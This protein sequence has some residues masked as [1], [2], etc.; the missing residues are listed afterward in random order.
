M[1]AINITIFLIL[2][3]GVAVSPSLAHD[4]WMEREN[5]DYVLYQGHRHSNHA[6]DDRVAYEP[7]IVKAITCADEEGARRT[8]DPP[9]AYPARIAGPCAALHVLTST[10]YWTRTTQGLRNQPRSELSGAIKSW[11]SLTGIKRL[12]A[13]SPALAAPLSKALEITPLDDPAALTPGSP[14]RLLITLA[15]QPQE[16]VAVTLDGEFQGVSDAAGQ[17]SIRLEASG[18]RFLG[19]RFEE[20]RADGLADATVHAATLMLELPE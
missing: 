19:A 20:P 15:G 10:G 5:G 18:L 17:V 16:G 8:I 1:Q 3:L 2:I 13:W 9:T 12:N 11:E 7:E 4:L 14:L 6:G